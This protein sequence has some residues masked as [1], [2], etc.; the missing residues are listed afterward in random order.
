MPQM[1][2]IKRGDRHPVYEYELLGSSVA[3]A[4]ATVRLLV[5]PVGSSGPAEAYEMEITDA[6]AR[7][8]RY[9]WDAGST[10][11]IGDFDTEVEVTYAD[12]RTETWPEDGYDRLRV[13]ADLG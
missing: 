7:R 2:S 4:G 12:G 6:S 11:A 9:E 5:R 10:D 1:F 13:V 8:V 3:L